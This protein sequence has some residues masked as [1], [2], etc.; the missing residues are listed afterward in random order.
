[1]PVLL[2]FG[3]D[4]VPFIVALV[5]MLLLLAGHVLGSFLSLLADNAP[6]PVNL[7]AGAVT[8]G[9][10]K[11]MRL[12]VATLDAV[13][14]PL[15]NGLMSAVVAPWTMYHKLVR[16]VVDAKSHAVSGEQQAQA[17]QA[18]A[19][20]AVG[21]AIDAPAKG[22][23]LAEQDA[24]SH[25]LQ[26]EADIANTSAAAV[27]A[28]LAPI[29][30]QISDV[31]S[32]IASELGTSEAYTDQQVAKADAFSQGLADQVQSEAATKFGTIDGA[33][34]NL[35][36][37]VQGIP[38]EITGTIDQVVPGMITGAIA[39]T[40]VAAIPGIIAQVQA[41]EAE[42]TTCLEPLCDTVTPNANQ[43][44]NLGKLLKD[45]ETL[46]EAGALMGL[47]VA[48]VED[49]KGTAAVVEETMGWVAPLSLDL[50]HAV[51]DAA[52]VVL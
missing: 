4:L 45:L 27:A 39:G 51:G 43:L 17:A 36:G 7:L 28:G 49:P 52:G 22:A 46:A 38:A 35:Q 47:L 23:A 16:G 48:A 10:Q 18:T 34:A 14:A 15:A 5:A 32:Q 42:A 25:Y 9:I 20:A 8:G 11:V 3:I 41:L 33:I 12:M 37:V 24:W 50:V 21:L 29:E 2:L 26:I 40:A 30:G 19:G 13:V 44:G 31:Q 1:M 6:F